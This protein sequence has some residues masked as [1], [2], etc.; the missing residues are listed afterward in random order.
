MIALSCYLIASF[1]SV[2]LFNPK[3]K[4]GLWRAVLLIPLII[5]VWYILYALNESNTYYGYSAYKFGKVLSNIIIPLII[6]C[7]ATYFYLN[8]KIKN[9]G[10]V[11]FPIILFVLIIISIGIN[12]F[13]K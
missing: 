4:L 10:K 13:F 3:N 2:Y 8:K 11:K 6:S 7:G 12:L 1:I 5:T 9:E